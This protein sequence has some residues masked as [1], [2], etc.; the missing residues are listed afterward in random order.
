[1]NKHRLGVSHRRGGLFYRLYFITVCHLHGGMLIASCNYLHIRK[2][3]SICHVPPVP[4]ESDPPSSIE[5]MLFIHKVTGSTK[6]W[7]HPY[8]TSCRLTYVNFTQAHVC[9]RKHLT[10][11]LAVSHPPHNTPSPSPHFPRL[12]HTTC[13]CAPVTF[14]F[15]SLLWEDSYGELLVSIKKKTYQFQSVKKGLRG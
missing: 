7:R 6:A 2:S 8:L 15:D 3:T 11:H 1:M 13:F 12:Q 10:S 4:H 9:T 14:V 5:Q